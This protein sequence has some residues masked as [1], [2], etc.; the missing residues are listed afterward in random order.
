MSRVILLVLLG[1]VAAYYFPDSRQ[2][3]IEVAQPIL[4]P[5]E[6]WST[7]EE[8]SQVGRNVIEHE[9]LTGQLPDRR[10]WLA[11]LD[12]RYPTEDLKRD[13]WD[14]VYQLKVWADSIGIVSYGP[15]LTGFT[16]DDFQVVV[17]RQ[18]AR[19]R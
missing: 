1:V 12:Y 18:R 16:E 17:P 5:V 10:S 7:Q 4:V 2:M 6:K 15:D 11:W 13:P 3:L 14:T 8:M 19:G 9:R